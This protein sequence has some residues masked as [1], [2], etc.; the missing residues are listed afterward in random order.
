MTEP[1]NRLRN[2]RNVCSSNTSSGNCSD[3]KESDSTLPYALRSSE[4]T[5]CRMK[6][7]K[8]RTLSALGMLFHPSTFYSQL[9]FNAYIQIRRTSLEIMRDID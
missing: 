8:E 9:H 4:L 5:V 3:R 7:K 2:V 1:M 6:P